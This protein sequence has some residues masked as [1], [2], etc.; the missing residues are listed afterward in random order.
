MA[1]WITSKFS[2]HRMRRLLYTAITV[3]AIWYGQLPPTAPAKIR[4]ALLADFISAQAEHWLGHQTVLVQQ[5]VNARSAM[6]REIERLR[7][8][9]AEST[10][11]A[12]AIARDTHALR[13]QYEE[14]AT[15]YLLL[16]KL[17]AEPADLRIWHDRLLDPAQLPALVTE[18]QIKR[19]AVHAKLDLAQEAHALYSQTAQQARQLRLE[20]EQ[21]IVT[22]NVYMEMLEASWL[23]GEV[24][25]GTPRAVDAA[26]DATGVAGRLRR[27]IDHNRRLV[28]QRH[29]LEEFVQGPAITPGENPAP[30]QSQT[31]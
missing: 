7:W 29:A 27:Q 12:N 22:M 1:K 25:G 4:S 26:T 3:L 16:T 11:R 13:A 17:V 24:Q 5:A 18:T 2:G 28:E 23:L 15:Q 9:E 8:I 19:D 21:N 20:M 31:H 14:L 10:L 6:T 30:A